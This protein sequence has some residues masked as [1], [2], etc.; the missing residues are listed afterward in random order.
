M[1]KN[2]L[3]YIV[4]ISVILGFLGSC[5]IPKECPEYRALMDSIPYSET[6]Y[7]PVKAISYRYLSD[8]LGEW[9]EIEQDEYF[10]YSDSADGTVTN[11]EIKV[12]GLLRGRDPMTGEV[13]VNNFDR[14]SDSRIISN[15]IGCMNIFFDTSD[16]SILEKLDSRENDTVY[17]KGRLRL[18]KTACGWNEHFLTC[19]YLVPGIFIDDA[20]DITLIQ[21][22]Q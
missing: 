4:S 9:T 16:H 13:S 3:I 2:I 22:K 15:P 8:P 7:N 14:F 18:Y 20:N 11:Q 1:K 10:I 12:F 5:T 21:K 17:L 6:D 19:I